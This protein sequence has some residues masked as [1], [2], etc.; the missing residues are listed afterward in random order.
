MYASIYSEIKTVTLERFKVAKYVII[1]PAPE[2]AG[3]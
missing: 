2:K 1:S 3:L